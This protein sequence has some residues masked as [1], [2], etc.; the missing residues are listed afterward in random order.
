VDDKALVNFHGD[1][2]GDVNIHYHDEDHHYYTD[3]DGVDDDSYFSELDGGSQAEDPFEGGST[4]DDGNDGSAT[5]DD[6]DG[7]GG[8]DNGSG[9]DDGIDQCDYNANNPQ[10]SAARD[11]AAQLDW[12][13]LGFI[14]DWT[15]DNTQIVPPD[16]SGNPQPQID[17]QFM[18]YVYKTVCCRDLNESI[19][20]MLTSFGF[21]PDELEAH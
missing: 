16:A 15:A 18:L 11:L 13:M 20:A 21:R 12:D 10:S 2:K 17:E 7:T 14:T 1:V 9:D 8:D 6:D 3:E 5:G 4:V 19:D